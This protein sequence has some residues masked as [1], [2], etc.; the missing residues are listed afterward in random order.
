MRRMKSR[1]T[2]G[3]LYDIVGSG[4]LNARNA[5]D[6][7]TSS[8]NAQLLDQKRGDKLGG[9]LRRA[10]P[11]ELS[12][13]VSRT[14]CQPVGRTDS[15]HR[16]RKRAEIVTGKT[17]KVCLLYK[18]GQKNPINLRA[19]SVEKKMRQWPE[20]MIPVDT[21]ECVIFTGREHETFFEEDDSRYD[22]SPNTDREPP[23]SSKRS[24]ISRRN[25][26]TM[27]LAAL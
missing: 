18:M 9:K 12:C 17:L 25:K 6:I 10:A 21:H 26:K 20:R 15:I 5:L 27:H 24:S 4:I 23:K 14:Q 13:I 1:R 7:M 8:S 2:T 19:Q 16:R 11:V 3:N 22:R